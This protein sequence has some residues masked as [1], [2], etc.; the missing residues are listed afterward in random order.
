MSD[1]L[2]FLI[3]FIAQVLF[4]SRMI[5]QWIQSEKAGRP[6]SPTLFWE[7]SILGALF[8]LLYAIL[9]KDFAILLGQIIVYFIY[10]RNLHF[11]KVWTKLHLLI[12]LIFI[13][14]PFALA[15][16]LFSSSPGNW[17]DLIRDSMIPD[18]LILWGS[19]GQVVFTLRFVVQWLESEK[20][21]QSVLSNAFWGISLVGS[22]MILSYAFLRKD[23]VLLIGQLTGS[24]LYTRN[25]ILAHRHKS[26]LMFHADKP[27]S[28]HGL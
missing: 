28:Q 15:G 27:F 4:M 23:P 24:I 11:K 25:L 12:R 20:R 16:Y 26:K 1:I 5:V 14:L 9:R 8:F 21:N 18:W 13:L 6:L 22:I 10:L 19:L 7:M 2:I 3:G 17:H